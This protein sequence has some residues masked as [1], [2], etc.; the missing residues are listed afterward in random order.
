MSKKKKKRTAGDWIRSIILI[1]ALGVFLFSAVKLVQIFL[2]YKEGTDEY[3]RVR[4]YVT[5]IPEEEEQEEENNTEGEEV[6]EEKPQAPQ[7]DWEGLLAKNKNVIGWIQIEG[8]EI[9]YPIMK[10]T[11]NSYYLKHTF[12]GNYNIAGSIF[13]DYMNSSDF[14]DCNTLIYG[15]NMKNGSM[16]GMLRKHFKDEASVPGKYIWVCTP[17]QNYRYEIFSSHVVDAAGEVYTL[18]PEAGEPFAEYLEHMVQQSMVD[19]KVPVTKD[20][21]IITLST[22]TGN[23]ATRFVVQAKREG[24]Y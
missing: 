3:N 24:A 2:E 12:E 13:V 21:K 6:Q 4:E 18:F 22:C 1:L 17:Q 7:V 16:F 10:G 15:H 11:D 20:D 14:E 23:D 9:S 5:A 19:Y 8:T